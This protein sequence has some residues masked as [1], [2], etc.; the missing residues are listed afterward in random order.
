MSKIAVI[1]MSAYATK[2]CAEPVEG[3][4]TAEKFEALAGGDGLLIAKALSRLGND[5]SFLSAVGNDEYAE[6]CLASLKDA[7]VDAHLV[8][9]ND[10]STSVTSTVYGTKCQSIQVKGAYLKP[11]DLNIFEPAINTADLTVIC[12][13]TPVGV[14]DAAIRACRKN[15]KKSAYILTGYEKPERAMLASVSVTLGSYKMRAYLSEQFC[16]A[17][18]SLREGCGVSWREGKDAYFAPS[19]QGSFDMYF[20]F[21]AFCAGFCSR[22]AAGAAFPESAYFARACAYMTATG[23]AVFP[24]KEQAEKAFSALKK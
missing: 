18:V 1:G 9:K 5:V 13:D 20:A 16:K 21:D 8:V 6:M 17:S 15:N 7:G 10:V 3:F 24:D 23:K 22:L 12:S 19:M 2:I 4:T 11:L 14:C